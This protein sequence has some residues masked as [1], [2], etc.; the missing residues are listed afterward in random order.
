MPY[1]RGY[2]W[3]KD[4]EA[5]SRLVGNIL[6]AVY[7]GNCGRA[8]RILKHKEFYWVTRCATPKVL[9]RIHRIVMRC[10]ERAA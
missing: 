7:S 4:R 3:V 8:E 5:A 9:A 2:C 10:Q 1:N 6:R